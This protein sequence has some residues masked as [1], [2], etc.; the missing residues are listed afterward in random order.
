M[1][2]LAGFIIATAIERCHLHKRMALRM[3]L[4]VG[5]EPKR[6]LFG[7]MLI[8]WF[9]AMWM[10]T[11]GSTV[12]MMLPI[13]EAILRRL[14]EMETE[15]KDIPDGISSVGKK[16]RENLGHM[17]S[18]DD[19]ISSLVDLEK[20]NDD[21]FTDIEMRGVDKFPEDKP[22]YPSTIS[23][24]DMEKAFTLSIAYAASIGGTAT[25]TGHSTNLIFK[26]VADQIYADKKA[27]TDPGITF[28]TWLMYGFPVSLL[29][30]V[31]TWFVLQLFFLGWRDTFCQDQVFKGKEEVNKVLRKEYESL[32]PMTYVSDGTAAMAVIFSLFVIPSNPKR[33]FGLAS[34]STTR[35]EGFAVW[36]Q[37]GLHNVAGGIMHKYDVHVTSRD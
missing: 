3:L 1:L 20:T 9:L 14:E 18:E 2:Q 32:G 5:T 30:T 13:V 35:D 34:D 4:L 36:L 28:A 37:P 31:C 10:S 8:T 17:A 23:I 29:V 15:N 27:L 19:S 24:K 11:T 16:Y 7:L 25:L 6:L 33:Y 26:D 12:A 21:G 22:K